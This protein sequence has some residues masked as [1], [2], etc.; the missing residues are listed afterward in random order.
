MK[1]Q[2]RVHYDEE[3]DF[4]EIASGIPTRCYA[5]EVQPG[6]FVRRDE[7]TKKVKSIGILSFK[8]RTHKLKDVEISLPYEVSFTPLH[9]Q[10]K[11]GSVI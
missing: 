3:G 7:K 9:Q 5:E 1:K 4:L 2:L 11:H 8:K 10:M 6:V